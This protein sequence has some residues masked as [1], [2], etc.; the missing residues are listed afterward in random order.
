MIVGASFK[1]ARNRNHMNFVLLWFYKILCARLR[2]A[3]RERLGRSALNN[4][5]FDTQA[6]IFSLFLISPN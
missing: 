4:P 6:I 5:H 3:R 2:L 1:P